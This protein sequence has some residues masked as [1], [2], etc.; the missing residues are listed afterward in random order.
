M[1]ICIDSSVCSPRCL[2]ASLVTSTFP[3]CKTQCWHHRSSPIIYL[4][5][6]CSC[7]SIIQT[8]FHFFKNT[9]TTILC[10]EG[11]SKSNHQT[12]CWVLPDNF[13]LNSECAKF[14]CKNIFWTLL[15][16]QP[17][18]SA[19]LWHFFYF[20]HKFNFPIVF[21]TGMKQIWPIRPLDLATS[22]P[23]NAHQ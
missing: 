1:N 8:L 7:H 23:Q 11:S 20:C 19:V 13:S 9:D 10:Y 17:F 3:H 12:S 18:T 22:A 5:P 14:V 4:S 6:S 21:P 2:A 15:L 16:Q